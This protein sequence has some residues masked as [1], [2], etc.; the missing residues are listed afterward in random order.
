MQQMTTM[1]NNHSHP[2]ASAMP[3]IPDRPQTSRRVV[4]VIRE[5]MTDQG[6]KSFWTK[7]GAAF[8][9]RDGSVTVRL[10]ALPMDGTL[11]IRDEDP[12][13]PRNT[14]NAPF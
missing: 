11:Q 6:T 8:E 14:V 9:N 10:D 7:V 2:T 1:T 5:K 4:Y 3:P 13:P 12:R